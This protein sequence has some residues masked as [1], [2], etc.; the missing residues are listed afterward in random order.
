[1]VTHAV[2]LV[3]DAGP[4]VE[5]FADN[6]APDDGV[7]GLEVEFVEDVVVARRVDLAFDAGPE[8]GVRV[9]SLGAGVVRVVEVLDY[10]LAGGIEDVLAG[11]L[12][13]VG[14]W[15]GVEERLT[16]KGTWWNQSSRLSG[17]VS[18]FLNISYT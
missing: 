7:A 10:G 8:P 5:E 1:V 11:S 3:R 18:M 17:V 15:V 4:V 16:V 12:M 6:V 14:E 13:Y 9:C 2:E